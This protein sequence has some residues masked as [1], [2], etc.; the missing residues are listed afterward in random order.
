M[1]LNSVLRN[2]LW[3]LP[4][5]LPYGNGHYAT[6]CDLVL[7]SNM[8][9]IEQCLTNFSCN[10]LGCASNNAPCVLNGHRKE[11]KEMSQGFNNWGHGKNNCCCQCCQ[12]CECCQC[13]CECCEKEE[14][15]PKCATLK[16]CIEKEDKKDDCC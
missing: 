11:K 9:C 12:C 15:K 8:I 1:Y 6:G 5:K 10:L 13:C 7:L 3:C 16:V 2:C 14:H 4:W